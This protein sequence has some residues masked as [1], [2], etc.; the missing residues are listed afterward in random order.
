M[1][2]KNT[3]HNEPRHSAGLG[4][5]SP[6]GAWV[7]LMGHLPDSVCP[8]IC[9]SVYQLRYHHYV[10]QTTYG[11]VDQTITLPA[12]MA[13]VRFE[14]N[15]RIEELISKTGGTRGVVVCI[16]TLPTIRTRSER[17]PLARFPR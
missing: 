5:R 17:V 10:Y 1:Y 16:G 15:H 7:V 13:L 14:Q 12:L 9:V 3:L 6:W 11:P 8:L 4:I 2:S